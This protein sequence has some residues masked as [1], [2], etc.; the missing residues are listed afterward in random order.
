M[1]FEIKEIQSNKQCDMCAGYSVMN[2]SLLMEPN[3][4][5]LTWWLPVLT[6][7]LILWLYI[8]RRW[9]GI[10]I[11]YTICDYLCDINVM[12]YDI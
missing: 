4:L 5:I 7:S 8:L 6:A 10:Y 2:L 12:S 1:G 11:G 9:D 3:V